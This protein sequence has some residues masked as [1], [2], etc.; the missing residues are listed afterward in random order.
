MKSIIAYLLAFRRDGHHCDPS[1]PPA[2]AAVDAASSVSVVRCRPSLKGKATQL[3]AQPERDRSSS[4]VTSE[5]SCQEAA[6]S[7]SASSEAASEEITSSES[8]Q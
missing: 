3:P 1:V 2:V 6:S 8:V 7:E 5:A 4:A